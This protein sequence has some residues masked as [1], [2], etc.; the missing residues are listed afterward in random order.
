MS[1]SEKKEI[2]SI[3]RLAISRHP[4]RPKS[5]DFIRGIFTNF[6]EIHGD[7]LFGDDPAM[8]TGFGYIDNQKCLIVAQEKGSDTDTRIARNFGMALPEG[9]RKALRAMKLAEKFHLP[10]V[11]FIDT[12]GAY[13]CLAAEERGQG[14]AIAENLK[15]MSGLKTP[16]IGVIIGE[17]CSGGA[18]GIG[19]CDQILMLEHAYYSVIAPEGCASILWKDAKKKDLAATALKLHPENLL[20]L[21]IIDEIIDEPKGG[22]HLNPQEVFLNLKKSLLDHLSKLQKLPIEKLLSLRYEKYRKIGKYLEL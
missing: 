8:I 2:S 15:Q 3:D 13:P 17:G 10:V 16:L 4:N 7:R 5:L 14:W 19:V 22:A 18:L 6:Q 1:F 21:E 20:A 9:Y 11:T 12:P